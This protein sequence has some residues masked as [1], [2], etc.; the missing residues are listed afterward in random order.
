MKIFAIIL[1]F[2]SA[3]PSVPLMAK[4]AGP[5]APPETGTQ[6]RKVFSRSGWKDQSRAGA[7]PRKIR[8]SSSK[9]FKRR[10][11]MNPRDAFFFAR[12]IQI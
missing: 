2:S 6:M 11:R 3:T 5:S 10:Q 12:S 7:L 4:P 1:D 9:E 8:R